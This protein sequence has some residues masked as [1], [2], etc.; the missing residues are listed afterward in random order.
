VKGFY[1][2]FQFVPHIYK[3]ILRGVCQERRVDHQLEDHLQ[4]DPLREDREGLVLQNGHLIVHSL[5]LLGW[6]KQFIIE[7]A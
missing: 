7:N 5:Q 4:D 2:E 3:G 6:R 1:I